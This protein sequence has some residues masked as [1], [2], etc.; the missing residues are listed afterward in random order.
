VAKII[1]YPSRS[2]CSFAKLKRTRSCSRIVATASVMNSS[3]SGYASDSGIPDGRTKPSEPIRRLIATLV[4]ELPATSPVEVSPVIWAPGTKPD[5]APVG[6]SHDSLRP[7]V[8]ENYPVALHRNIA[9][10]LTPHGQQVSVPTAI[11]F[12]LKAGR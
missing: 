4:M 12:L 11:T 3:R 8:H 9:D 6:G 7:V 2:N 10:E 1:L 5:Y